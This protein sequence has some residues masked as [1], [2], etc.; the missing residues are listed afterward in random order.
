MVA[1]ML[2]KY[3]LIF[4]IFLSKKT[5]IFIFNQKIFF[6][7]TNF[8]IETKYIYIQSKYTCV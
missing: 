1:E 7:C 8:V 3:I 6:L 5:D 4:N 2:Q